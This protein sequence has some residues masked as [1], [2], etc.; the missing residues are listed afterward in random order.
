MLAAARS[1]AALCE[2]PLSSIMAASITRPS[3]PEKRAAEDELILC[4]STYSLI[5]PPISCDT[6]AIAQDKFTRSE[7]TMHGYFRITRGQTELDTKQQGTDCSFHLVP[8]SY[9]GKPSDPPPSALVRCSSA[10]N[11]D[12]AQ[13]LSASW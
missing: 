13:A 6:I 11:D 9:W 12:P 1:L 10:G 7:T 2:Q 4:V 3:L 8:A 5:H